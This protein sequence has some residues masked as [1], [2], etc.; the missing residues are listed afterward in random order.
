MHMIIEGEW[1]TQLNVNQRPTKKV[2]NVFVYIHLWYLPPYNHVSWLRIL[3]QSHSHAQTH[4]LPTLSVAVPL[5]EKL[6]LWACSGVFIRALTSVKLRHRKEWQCRICPNPSCSHSTS[7][8][9][10]KRKPD[11]KHLHISYSTWAVKICPNLTKKIHLQHPTFRSKLSETSKAL[12]WSRKNS[13][14]LLRHKC[15]VYTFVHDVCT[16]EIHEHDMTKKRGYC[17]F[18]E[19]GKVKGWNVHLMSLFILTFIREASRM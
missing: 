19:T 18:T 7:V 3:Q 8:A 16:K 12:C 5:K 17:I 10:I 2:I 11:P 13:V 6:N 9:N 15:T 4:H 14:L 1:K